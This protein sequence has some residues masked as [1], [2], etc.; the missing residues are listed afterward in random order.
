MVEDSERARRAHVPSVASPERYW[1][2]SPLSLGDPA[3]RPEKPG[4]ASYVIQ[5]TMRI[6]QQEAEEE[7]D[8]GD[9]LEGISGSQSL[10]MG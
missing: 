1:A 7:R 8:Q 4:K 9:N 10:N 2:S 5:R 3:R 6:L